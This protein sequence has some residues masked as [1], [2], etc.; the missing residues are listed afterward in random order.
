M[1]T[2]LAAIL[3]LSSAA[4]GLAES[5]TDN[6]IETFTGLADGVAGIV[7]DHAGNDAQRRD[8]AYGAEKTIR[9]TAH[10]LLN[11]PYPCHSGPHPP[12]VQT[13][14][15]AYPLLSGSCV[16]AIGLGALQD[17]TDMDDTIAVGTYAG[18]SL[19]TESRDLLIGDCT[20]AP[21]GK[22]GFVNIANKLCFWRDT[23]IIEDC[24]PPEP[25]CHPPS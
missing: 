15:D 6:Q 23:G 8:L 18:A 19:R 4:S 3:I 2:I 22:D 21:R 14:G 25:Q 13:D 24:P 10:S 7:I 5:A 9:S 17:A 1:R 20:A 11:A 12:P 16:I